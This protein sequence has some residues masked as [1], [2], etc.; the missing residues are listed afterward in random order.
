MLSYTPR[1]R[2]TEESSEVSNQIRDFLEK[3]LADIELEKAHT[4]H[5]I[6]SAR[7]LKG[8]DQRTFLHKEIYKEFDRGFKSELVQSYYRMAI[9]CWEEQVRKSEFGEWLI[10]R[11]PSVRIQFPLNVSVFEF[12]VDADYSHPRAEVNHFVAIT[13]CC[14]TASLWVERTLGCKDY[15]PLELSSGEFAILN[16]SVFSHGDMINAEA[17]TRVSIDFRLVP[18][19]ALTGE[20]DGRSL[21]ANKK[22]DDSDYYISIDDIREG[23][24]T[25]VRV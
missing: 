8:T 17:Y 22:F 25:V 18:K 9:E 7:L 12:H 2:R 5:L 23:L 3:K 19:C 24:K 13:D 16:T 1:I 21:T 20:L 10:Q 4:F 11:Y 14:R 15:Q 6:D